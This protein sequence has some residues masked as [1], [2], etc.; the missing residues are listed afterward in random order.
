MARTILRVILVFV[1]LTVAGYGQSMN[2]PYSLNLVSTELNAN[3]GGRRIVRSW[4]QKRLVLLGDGVSVAL[5]KILDDSDLKNPEKVRDLLPIIRDA[6][7]RPESIA[8]EADRKPRVTLFL[9]NYIR[10][11]ISD[12]EAQSEVQKTMDFIGKGP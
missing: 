11:N 1:S 4:A 12:S 2:D 5:L 10:Q 8:I 7:S 9:L 3:S 6:F